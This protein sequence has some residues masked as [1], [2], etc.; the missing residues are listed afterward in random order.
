MKDS[1]QM[2]PRSQL[3]MRQV[4]KSTSSHHR[5]LNSLQTTATEKWKLILIIHTSKKTLAQQHLKK[6]KQNIQNDYKSM[7]ELKSKHTELLKQWFCTFLS[8]TR[9]TGFS[10]LKRT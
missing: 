7:K 5:G 6:G 4:G 9:H 2:K 10:R 8:T 1:R 3:N